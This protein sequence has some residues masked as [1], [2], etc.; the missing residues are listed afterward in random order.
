MRFMVIV[1]ATRESENDVMPSDAA[2]AAMGRYN[3]ELIA[4]GVMLAAD[5]LMSSR[6]GA[7][8]KSEGGR[9]TVSDGPF[10]ETKE[11]I[12]GYWILDVK[13]K[14][15]VLAWV[16]KIPF[17]DGEEIEVRRLF[18]LSDFGE[19]EGVEQHRRNDEALLGKS[20]GAPS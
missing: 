18:E 7:R 12:A 19:G 10:A 6:H 13:D 11:L 4:A 15:E 17:E 14:D 9:L 16:K 20:A 5:G 8:V 3:E 2:L 1:K